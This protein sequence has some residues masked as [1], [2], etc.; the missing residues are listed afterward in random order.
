MHNDQ[1]TQDARLTRLRAG[2]SWL[3]HSK[4][5]LNERSRLFAAGLAEDPGNDVVVADL[6]TDVGID[7]LEMLADALPPGAGALRIVFGRQPSYGVSTAGWW[8]A[9]ALNRTVVVAEGHPRSAAG[10][11]LFI[12]AERGRGWVRYD[13]QTG[14]IP[15]SRRFPR[16]SWDATMPDEPQPLSG[17]TIAEPIPTGMWLHAA[18]MSPQQL[19]I[20]R[21]RLLSNLTVADD[22]LTVVVGVPGVPLISR[23][24]IAAF[25]ESIPQRVRSAVRFIQYSP[26]GPADQDLGE[27]LANTIGVPVRLYN[28][29]PA[30]GAGR[31][32]QM[33]EGV[34]A[35]LPD[36]S[37][38]HPRISRESVYYP[39]SEERAPHHTVVSHQWPLGDVIEVQ[40]GT[41][42]YS[43][44]VVMEVVPGG[45]WVRPPSR[46]VPPASLHA[47]RSGQA[48]DFMVVTG[49]PAAE[50]ILTDAANT[51]A[52]RLVRTLRPSVRMLVVPLPAEE[53][54]DT[55]QLPLVKLDQP[56]GRRAPHPPESVSVDTAARQALAR[57]GLP[58]AWE[59]LYERAV[60]MVQD[61]FAQ[62]PEIR[63]LAFGDDDVADLVSLA[64]YLGVQHGGPKNATGSWPALSFPLTQALSRL[65]SHTGAVAARVQLGVA[66]MHSYVR[67]EVF[68]EPMPFCASITGCSGHE[69]D[70]D[71]VIWSRTARRTAFL[72]PTVPQQVFFLPETRFKVLDV[73]QAARPVVLLMEI[74]PDEDRV[75]GDAIEV[76][77]RRDLLHSHRD[78][79]RDEET[80]HAFGSA[81]IRGAQAI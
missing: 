45:L 53:E 81:A 71:V 47:M 36:G 8:L 73:I 5:H 38:G 32:A 80:V 63:R 61:V 56:V 10:G 44:D 70:T 79:M 46:P 68:A 6:P 4:G 74:A 24:E 2:T 12:P 26:P 16:P 42:R 33:P 69:G 30:G 35:V 7:G 1:T 20:H 55:T 41:F 54:D 64:T 52:R 59:H 31:H 75:S 72:Q 18:W 25:W 29:I 19:A 65:P 57:A 17:A 50:Q 48:H 67:N 23:T 49:E 78:W 34:Y 28:G 43:E 13:T 27:A 58:E 66:G 15:V 11:R 37:F 9:E 40:P 62:R 21:D 3:V 77:I 60:S 39:T 22:V 76:R 51:I 14:E